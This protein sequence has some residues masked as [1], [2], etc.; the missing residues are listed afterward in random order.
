MDQL[1]DDTDWIIPF[2]L[3]IPLDEPTSGPSMSYRR[4]DAGSD[5]SPIPFPFSHLDEQPNDE[6]QPRLYR[7]DEAA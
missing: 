6:F 1:S 7:F 3:A 5:L 4:E 2:H